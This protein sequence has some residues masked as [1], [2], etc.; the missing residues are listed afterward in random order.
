M[1]YIIPVLFLLLSSCTTGSLRNSS[2]PMISTNIGGSN[3]HVNSTG[4]MVI[5][6]QSIFIDRNGRVSGSIPT[7]PLW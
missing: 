4:V 2:F 7:F 3:V 5:G 1:K 6:N